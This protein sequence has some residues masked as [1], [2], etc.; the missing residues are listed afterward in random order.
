MKIF[1]WNLNE[2]LNTNDDLIL[3]LGGFESLHLGHNELFKLAKSYKN[4]NPNSKLAISIFANS[5]KNN[6]VIEKK[7]L[8]LKVRLYI[9]ANLDFDYVFIITPN[10]EIINI[11]DNKFIEE[12]KKMNIKTIICGQDYRFG[13]NHQGDIWKLKKHFNVH[14]ANEKKVNHS[15]I[16]THL[17]KE[18]ISEGNINYAN[19]LL[20][21]KYALIIKADK[22]IFHLPE[23]IIKIKSGIYVVNAIIKDIEYHGLCLISKYSND[24]KLYLFDITTIPS[25]HQEIYTEFLGTIRYIDTKQNDNINDKDLKIAKKYL[26]SI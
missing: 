8:Q 6:E 19:E 14:V 4:D 10:K 13:F 9:L 22:F 7:L 11:S 25:K 23:N 17:I 2:K 3:C 15:K 18:L 12:L 24:N 21:E 5:I 20:L 16:S 1:N 26:E